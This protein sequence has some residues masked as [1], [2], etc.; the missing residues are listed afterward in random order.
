M[1]LYGHGC[2][3]GAAGALDPR[4]QLPSSQMQ[5]EGRRQQGGAGDPGILQGQGEA[6]GVSRRVSTVRVTGFSVD[7]WV[8]VVV[9]FM[10]LLSLPQRCLR[11]ATFRPNAPQAP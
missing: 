8:V 1:S 5:C 4:P 10:R 2:I 11:G 6:G 9:L 3:V 7:P